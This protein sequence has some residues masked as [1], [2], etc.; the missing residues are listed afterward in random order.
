MMSEHDYWITGYSRLKA[1]QG[2][3]SGKE[4]L[5]DIKIIQSLAPIDG[6]KY[7]FARGFSATKTSC[8]VVPTT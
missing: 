2:G 1:R 4:G 3:D 8:W 6:D 7:G 5:S